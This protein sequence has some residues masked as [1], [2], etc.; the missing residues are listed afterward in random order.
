MVAAV[1]GLQA[2]GAAGLP[3]PPAPPAAP[4]EYVL[5]SNDKLRVIVFGED[6]LSGEF[7]VGADGR[8]AFPLIGSIQA[9]GR[10]PTEVQETIAAAL[11][12]GYVRDPRVSVEVLKFRPFYILGEVQKPGEYP[13]STGMTVLKAVATAGGFSYRANTRRVYIRR[14]GEQAEHVED[15]K[16]STAVLAGDTVRI[17]ERFF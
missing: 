1:L 16:P 12:S 6:Q 17:G 7:S 4:P 2:T 9:G 11:R 5:G 14:L 15:L 3:P 8:I 13:F 10:P